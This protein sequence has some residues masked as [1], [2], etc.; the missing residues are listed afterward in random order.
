MGLE[1]I[2]KLFQRD[3]CVA[4]DALQS[5]GCEVRVAWMVT[6][7]SSLASASL[8][9]PGQGPASFTWS[10]SSRKSLP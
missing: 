6:R 8:R 5:A 10:G 4:K 2:Y 3:S 1:C 9:S 7:L